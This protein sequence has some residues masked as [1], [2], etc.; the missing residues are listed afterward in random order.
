MLQTSKKLLPRSKKSYSFWLPV[1]SCN[2]TNVHCMQQASF[3]W[4][5]L[6]SRLNMGCE[7]TIEIMAN[8]SVN[9][10]RKFQK[11]TVSSISHSG[12]TEAGRWAYITLDKA[13]HC[14][15][16]FISIFISISILIS[17]QFIKFNFKISFH[18]CISNKVLFQYLGNLL[19]NHCKSNNIPFSKILFAHASVL[20]ECCCGI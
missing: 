5:L 4:A 14:L 15:E 9:K 17:F 11:F 20:T 10:V 8:I 3:P 1:P 7:N 2:Y 6:F 16:S 19:R 13:G 12:Y 18:W